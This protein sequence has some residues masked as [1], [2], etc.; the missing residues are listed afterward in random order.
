MER[1]LDRFT[2]GARRRLDRFAL[3]AARSLH[4]RPRPLGPEHDAA[5]GPGAYRRPR[6]LRPKHTVNLDRF[7]NTPD[8]ALR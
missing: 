1:A 4:P 5:S 2:P 7:T 3:N 6:P 8:R